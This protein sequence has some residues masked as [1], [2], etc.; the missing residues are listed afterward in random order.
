[1]AGRHK[2]KLNSLVYFGAYVCCL[3]CM[4]KLIS[5]VIRKM[6]ITYT[7]IYMYGQT[8]SRLAVWIID[9]LFVRFTQEVLPCFITSLSSSLRNDWNF[10]RSIHWFHSSGSFLYQI[11]TS[12]IFHFSLFSDLRSLAGTTLLSLLASL[13]MGQLL[14]V[15]GVGGIQVRN[16]QQMKGVKVTQKN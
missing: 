3:C 1:M 12:F 10:V 9:R 2:H 8:P 5:G 14:F 6:C 16:K 15:I 11:S 4:L 7:L 13:F